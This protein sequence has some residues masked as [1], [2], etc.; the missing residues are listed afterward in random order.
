MIIVGEFLF[1]KTLSYLNYT[2]LDKDLPSVLAG[3]YD[4]EEY[5][6]SIQYNKAN[7]KYGLFTSSISFILILILISTGF[8]GFLD[9]WIRQYFENEIIISLA[10]FGIL[11]ISSDLLS[12]P[13]SPRR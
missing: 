6:R 4:P 9:N 13:F 10:F 2:Y 12:T 11:Y 8:F 5:K 7:S 3:I 1:E